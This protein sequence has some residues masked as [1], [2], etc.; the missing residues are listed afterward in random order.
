MMCPTNATEVSCSAYKLQPIGQTHSNLVA[1]VNLGAKHVVSLWYT[2]AC[3]RYLHSCFAVNRAI[4]TNHKPCSKTK[5]LAVVCTGCWT[6][7]AI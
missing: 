4:A 5:H 7:P 6:L 2:I 3:Q 1:R